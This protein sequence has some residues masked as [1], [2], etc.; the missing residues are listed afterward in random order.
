MRKGF[1]YLLVLA[2]AFCLAGCLEGLTP[3]TT[4]QIHWDTKPHLVING[5]TYSTNGDAVESLPEN[6]VYVG[7]VTA[8][9]AVNLP[10]LVGCKI[11]RS[12]DYAGYFIYQEYG[13]MKDNKTCYSWCY[14]RY[15][16]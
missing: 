15:V 7:D 16:H 1:V 4:E 9:Q 8:E 6:A 14:V 11:Y 5:M 13:F 3:E 12:E 10:Q 2:L